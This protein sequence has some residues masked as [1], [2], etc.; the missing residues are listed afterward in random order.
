MSYT[1][2]VYKRKLEPTKDLIG[3]LAFVSFFP[4]LVAGPIERAS[5]LLPQF[6]K[7][8]HFDYKKAVDGL[9]QM[10]WGLFK[11]MVIADN[12]ANFAN[13]TFGGISD[14]NGSALV[15]G[16]I[17]FTIQI[18]ADF[19]GY[20]D[21]AIG[22][23]RL[24]G[25]N[26]MKNFSYPYFSRNIPEAWRKW[27]ISLTTWFRD[28]LYLPLAL[29]HRKS[30]T[31]LAFITVLQFLVIGFWHG[32]N[33]TFIV[34]GAIHATY[35]LPFVLF[36]KEMVQ[37]TGLV[38]EGKIMPSVKEMLQMMKVFSLTGFSM[39]FFRAESISHAWAYLN[40]IFSPSLLAMPNLAGGKKALGIILMVM[41][42]FLVEWLYRKDKHSL[43]TLGLNW[44]R[45]Y[46]WALYGFLG[47]LLFYFGGARQDFIYFD[48]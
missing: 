2:D 5:N 21:I 30:T 26:L 34:W 25:F 40:G 12:C 17:F 10:L 41:V 16:A 48:F 43:E 13:Q 9:R 6:Y 14:Y 44:K 15:L 42:F 7:P 23:A 1:I 36:R 47:I 19:S 45:R 33:W 3:F 11:K 46:R 27:H 39:I 29:K 20:S 24:F 22:T 38:A 18:Y 28:Y 37:Y 35:M 8:R 4:Q 31:K 32:A